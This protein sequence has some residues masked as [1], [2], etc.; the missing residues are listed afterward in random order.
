MPPRSGDGGPENDEGAQI[1]EGGG[2]EVK[3]PLRAN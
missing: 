3:F 1:D 2:E